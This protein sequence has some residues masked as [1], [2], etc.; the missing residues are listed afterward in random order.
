MRSGRGI[1]ITRSAC[2]YWGFGWPGEVAMMVGGRSVTYKQIHE[3]KVARQKRHLA[4]LRRVPISRRIVYVWVLNVEGWI[5][6]G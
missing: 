3:Q 4:D 1:V 5:Y 2:D 6:G